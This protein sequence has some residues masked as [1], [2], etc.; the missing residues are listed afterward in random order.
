MFICVWPRGLLIFNA[1]LSSLPLGRDTADPIVIASRMV[2]YHMYHNKSSRVTAG[3][4]RNILVRKARVTEEASKAL[5]DAAHL[6]DVS[7]STQRGPVE[8]REQEKDVSLSALA[9]VCALCRCSCGQILQKGSLFTDDSWPS[10]ARSKGQRIPKTASD[11]VYSYIIQNLE[12]LCAM[13]VL[14]EEQMAQR[15]VVKSGG[16]C[17]IPPYTRIPRHA[18]LAFDLLFEG[19]ALLTDEADCYTPTALQPIPLSKIIDRYWSVDGVMTIERLRE[20]LAECLQAD[21][22]TIH[23]RPVANVASDRGIFAIFKEANTPESGDTSVRS[24]DSAASG[25]LSDGKTTPREGSKQKRLSNA[26]FPHDRKFCMSCWT[27]FEVLNQEPLAGCHL[28]IMNGDERSS[29]IFAPH[30]TESAVVA[31]CRGCGPIVLGPVRNTLFLRG[32][33]ECTVSAVCSRLVIERCENITVYV[34][35]PLTPLLIDCHEVRL[36]PYNAPYDITKR[37]NL[38]SGKFQFLE[39]ALD[40][41]GMELYASNG[42]WNQPLV[43]YDLFARGEDGNS[44][45]CTDI[46]SIM[47]ESEFDLL[48]L[49]LNQHNGAFYKVLYVNFFCIVSTN[50]LGGAR[51]ACIVS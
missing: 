36:G 47:D 39:F 24:A 2:Q 13:V 34:A 11:A 12:E 30:Y 5:F 26:P 37:H 10:F 21:P 14:C 19:C 1:D 4:W 45:E 17:V 51:S 7:L 42:S 29:W 25:A 15:Y 48:S 16:G 31:N 3:E 8:L 20:R 46:F 28:R 9:L 50:L 41:A 43:V 38:V 44:S 40:E 49:P 22:F 33:A 35:V 6:V 32:L 23:D 27:H 18:L